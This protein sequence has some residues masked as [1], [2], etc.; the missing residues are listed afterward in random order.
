M[1]IKLDWEIQAEKE[2]IRGAGEDPDAKRRRRQLRFRFILTML[3]VF[4]LIGGAVGAV[5][6]R[7]RQADWEIEQRLRDSVAAEVAMLRIGDRSSFADM[8]RS[9]SDEWTRSQLA[10]FDRYQNLKATQDVNLTGRIVDLE[11]DGMRARVIVEEII[12]GTPFARTWFYW[13]YLD[14]DGWRWLHVPPD[15]TFWGDMRSLSAD[16]LTVRFRDVDSPTA[17]AMFAA[18][19]SWFEFGCAALRC[20]TIPPITISIEPN[21]L[22]QMGWSAF[23]PALLQIPSPYLVA[24]RLDQPFDRSMQVETARLV[25]DYL[26][27]TIQPVQPAYPADAVYLRSAIINWL[28]GRFAQ[29]D[30]GAYLLESLAQQY[31]TE[32][33]GV[34][35]HSLTPDAS[36]AL[37]NA[38][39]G[40]ASLDQVRVDWRDFLTWR[41]RVESELIA[42]GEANAV[43]ALYDTRDDFGRAL[44]AARI[45]AGA[46][47]E[48]RSVVSVMPGVDASGIPTLSALVQVGDSGREET[49]PFRLFNG[50][51]S[52]AG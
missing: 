3:I 23:E 16:S 12:N 4:G 49:I 39:A 17:E 24:M 13:R 38:A 29:I 34:L 50:I 37:V 30:T 15:Y 43:F 46:P 22:L 36:I 25:A 6:L 41:L 18:I 9:A 45:A 31:G 42:R 20:Q 52:R 51:W 47:Q 2:Q 32:S 27:R 28:M 7:L 26:I 5:W 35:L 48:A 44:A 21:P 8:Q 1:S 11:V 10:E 19:S 40:T 33:V 14:E